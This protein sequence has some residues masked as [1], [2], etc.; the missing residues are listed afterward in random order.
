MFLKQSILWGICRLKKHILNYFSCSADKQ[1]TQ[2][3]PCNLISSNVLCLLSSPIGQIANAVEP[4]GFDRKK[5]RQDHSI[6]T[7][8]SKE[9]VLIK[10]QRGPWK[11][12]EQAGGGRGTKKIEMNGIRMAGAWQ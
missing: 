9:N 2:A 10:G 6:P 12:T 1:F 5:N 8:T 7:A 11:P 4:F 3:A